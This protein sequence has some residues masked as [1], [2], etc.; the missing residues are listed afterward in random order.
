VFCIRGRSGDGKSVLLLQL[1]AALLERRA[2]A[3][4]TGLASFDD[5]KD[6]LRSRPKVQPGEPVEEVELAYI[7]DLPRRIDT[8]GLTELIE[9][10][11]AFGSRPAALL[12]CAITEDLPKTPSIEFD[13]FN[14]PQPSAED[15]QQF[16]AWLGS[17]A[18]HTL[19]VLRR[20][21]ANEVPL[22]DQIEQE[23]SRRGLW[24][25]ARH[26]IAA[27]MFGLPGAVLPNQAAALRSFTFEQS[28][29]T[30]R[31]DQRDGGFELGHAEF[32]EPLYQRWLGA[33]NFPK[34]W[35]HDLGLAIAAALQSGKPRLARMLLGRMVDVRT[36]RRRLAHLPNGGEQPAGDL[37]FAAFA[38]AQAAVD[39]AT[40]APVMRQ[41]LVAH[42]ATKGSLTHG[43]EA[44]AAALL[45]RPEVALSNKAEIALQLANGR[46]DPERAGA[47][48][49]ALA[50]L[51]TVGDEPMVIDY[52]ARLAS[53]SDASSLAR[54]QKWLT[55]HQRSLSAAPV[56][57]TAIRAGGPHVANY[58]VMG[59]RMVGA[60]PQD[61]MLSELVRTLAQDQIEP[62]YVGSIDRWL[63]HP[64]PPRRLSAIYAQLL[65][66]RG[67]RRYLLRA[68]NWLEQNV[69]TP[70]SHDLLVRLIQM[71][72][73]H[74]L[75]P[76]VESWLNAHPQ[77]TGRYSVIGALL[78]HSPFEDVGL[79]LAL[80]L[81][82]IPARNEHTR[83]LAA[84]A[85][86]VVK[87]MTAHDI[88]ALAKTLPA[89]LRKP[90]ASLRG[91]G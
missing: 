82:A 18:P 43:F 79:R 22:A 45:D 35:G 32:L 15:Q 12:T 31:A 58:R 53:R 41:W 89:D 52:Y 57:A 54:V 60:H 55:R 42:R 72:S 3:T 64:H 27:N 90:L 1:V 33:T 14:M 87:A 69:Q 39:D 51:E 56:L 11:F 16:S 34:A 49:R 29:I 10:S 70:D 74:D 48:T 37:L 85:S 66:I 88:Y 17:G 75:G 68:S 24:T 38:A 44:R 50:Y 71:Q 81:L 23:L 76:L 4:V 73:A 46:A 78:T 5:L 61:A 20:P 47:R 8:V 36:M 59:F 7:D 62:K 28:G 77:D 9:E 2:I 13:F 21:S 67:A 80:E 25:T 65:K 86:P 63:A 26:V 40:M 6:W 91:A 83:Y 19:A 30:L 84:L